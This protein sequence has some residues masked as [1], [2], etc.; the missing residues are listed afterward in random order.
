VETFGAIV[1]SLGMLAL[2]I[3]G[4]M[5]IP[6]PALRKRRPL[7]KKLAIGGL[8]AFIF[9]MAFGPKPAEN[10]KTP[11]ASTQAQPA[12]QPKPT[13]SPKDEHLAAQDAFITLYRQIINQTKRCDQASSALQKAANSGDTLATYQAAK[14]GRDACREATTTIGG[15]DAPDGLSDEAEEA[16]TKAI[17]TCENG[18]LYR[19]MGMEKAMQYADGDTRPSVMSEMI[20]NMKTG[21][22]GTLLCVT[23]LFAAA[24]KSGIDI[25]RLN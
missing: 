16:T 19:Q 17:T 9:G 14:E 4:L 10:T 15:Y 8:A 20:D 13:P 7:A 22:A 23:Q 18:Y 11:S 1:G 5:F 12:V 6:L 25:K 24:N 3:G 21:Q 2:I